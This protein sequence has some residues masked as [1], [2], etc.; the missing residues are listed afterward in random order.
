MGISVSDPSSENRL[1]PMYLVCRN[2]SKAS[3]A[4]S[5]DSTRCCMSLD[6]GSVI[7]SV[8]KRSWSHFVSVGEEICMNSTPT[9]RV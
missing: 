4:F 1:W 6:S 5:F 3:A 2:R 8:S 9:W 7:R